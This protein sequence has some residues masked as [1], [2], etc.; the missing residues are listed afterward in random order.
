[1]KKLFTLTLSVLIAAF[2]SCSD[3]DETNDLLTYSVTVTSGGHGTASAD[4]SKAEPGET[5]TLT[6]VPDEGYVFASWFVESG[7]V[8]L[9]GLT[10]NPATFIMSRADVKIVASFTEPGAEPHAVTVT[11]EKGGTV[12]YEPKEAKA[13]EIVK[14][15][16]QADKGYRFVGWKVEK[17]GV[18][19]IETEN[20]LQTGFV[21]GDEEVVIVAQ[22]EV[23]V[24]TITLDGNIENGKV[25]IKDGLES[26]TEG[27][28]ITLTAAPDA[29]YKFAGWDLGTYEL[30]EDARKTNPLMVKMP[31]A[32]LQIS[33]QFITPIADV[34]DVIEDPAFKAYAQYRMNHAQAVVVHSYYIVDSESVVESETFEEPAW[35]K[36]GDG[37][38]SEEE[39]AAIRAIDVSKEILENLDGFGW[40]G[41]AVRSLSAKGYFLGLEVLKASGQEIATLDANEFRALKVLVCDNNGLQTVYVN[42]C[43]ALTMLFVEQNKLTTLDIS[44]NRS[45]HS[46]SCY[47][48]HLAELNIGNMT[49]RKDNTYFLRAGLQ[50]DQDGNDTSLLLRGMR[51]NQVNCWNSIIANDKLP[52]LQYNRRIGVAY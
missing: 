45:L 35:D 24:Y 44:Q 3:D 50:T 12:A 9:S 41:T 40:D 20:P 13:G 36:D 34:L 49:F 25:E 29:G 26:A 30:S 5:V 8:T 47:S 32:D 48:N 19:L 14:I 27:T 16:A 39:A 1:M 22:F 23:A 2:V 51:A 7:D 18:E 52:E 21:M 37:K 11:A 38:L 31:A 43:A 17:G 10:E 42:K 4:L 6:A 46:L 28:I 15:A 33:A